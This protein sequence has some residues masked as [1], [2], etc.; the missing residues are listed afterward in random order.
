M[1]IYK[2]K[3]ASNHRKGTVSEE[4]FLNLCRKLIFYGI[5]MRFIS[6]NIDF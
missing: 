1:G 3:E 5:F 2:V 6:R 4:I